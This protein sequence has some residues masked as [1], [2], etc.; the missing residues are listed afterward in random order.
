MFVVV[1][2]VLLLAYFFVLITLST[3]VLECFD[4]YYMSHAFWLAQ[5]CG[6]GQEGFEKDGILHF[7]H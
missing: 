3:V 6:N 2:V 1:I 5:D 7:P 4:L